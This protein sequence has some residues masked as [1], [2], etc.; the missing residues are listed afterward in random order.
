MNSRRMRC[1]EYVAQ[2]GENRNAYRSLVGKPEGR[3]SLEDQ[4]AGGWIILEW[5][6]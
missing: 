2:R 4:D 6:L 1:T 5:I 3:R